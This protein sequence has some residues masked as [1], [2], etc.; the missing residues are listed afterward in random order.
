ML[1]TGLP[2]V[3]GQDLERGGPTPAGEAERAAGNR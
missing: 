2:V 3:E 1:L